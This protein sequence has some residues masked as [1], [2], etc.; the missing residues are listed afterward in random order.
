ME[1]CDV[2]VVLTPLLDVFDLG[3]LTGGVQSA[4][5]D[6]NEE[7]LDEVARDVSRCVFL[8]TVS[9]CVFLSTCVAEMCVYE[10]LS[11]WVCRC[12]FLIGVDRANRLTNEKD[13]SRNG[14]KT[15]ETFSCARA[16]LY[17]PEYVLLPSAYVI[18]LLVLDTSFAV[19]AMAYS[20]GRAAGG[21]PGTG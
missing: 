19:L 17:T 12:V 21:R 20:Y 6:I 5:D 7:V 14:G 2:G 8:S 1:D 15:C 11:G 4:I 16:L 10:L 3:S 13:V 18:V 9:R